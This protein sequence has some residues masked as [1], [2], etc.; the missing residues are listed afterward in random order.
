MRKPASPLLFAPQILTCITVKSIISSMETDFFEFAICYNICNL[1]NECLNQKRMMKE[2]PF[3]QGLFL[4]Q[5]R[6]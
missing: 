5:G 1:T 3:V 6:P 4:E 2:Q